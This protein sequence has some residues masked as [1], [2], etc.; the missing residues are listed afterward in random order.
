MKRF[1]APVIAIA[2][3]AGFAASAPALAQTEARTVLVQKDGMEGL[4]IGAAQK[5]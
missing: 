2:M 1:I 3:A 5:K 4:I